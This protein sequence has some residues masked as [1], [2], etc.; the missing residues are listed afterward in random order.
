MSNLE[1][2]KEIGL[3]CCVMPRLGLR[4]AALAGAG[5]GGIIV[6]LTVVSAIAAHAKWV[7]G[8]WSPS[9]HYTTNLTAFEKVPKDRGG[10]QQ[11]W[12]LRR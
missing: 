3:G 10:R 9:G 7:A 6:K 12:D 4:H 11:A 5:G 2:R 8:A 1:A